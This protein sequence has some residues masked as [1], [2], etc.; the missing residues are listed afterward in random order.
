MITVSILINGQPIF[1]R[2]AVHRCDSP[3]CFGKKGLH[4]YT[5]DDASVI[6]H[7]PEEGAVVLAKKMLDTIHEVGTPKDSLKKDGGKAS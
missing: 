5:L 6:Q 4:S 3:K 2:S 1:T 7:F